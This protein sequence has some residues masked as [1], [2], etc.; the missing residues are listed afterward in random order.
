MDAA[1]KAASSGDGMSKLNHFKFC[2]TAALAIVLIVA[3]R[4]SAQDPPEISLGLN[5][6]ATYYGGDIDS[7]DMTTGRLKL[8]IPLLTDNSQRGGLNF[9]YNLSYSSPGGWNEV[10]TSRCYWATSKYGVVGVGVTGGQFVS[11]YGV[12]TYKG[13][14]K[15]F[16]MYYATDGDGA[17]HTL[18]SLTQNVNGYWSSPARS[19]DGSKIYAYTNSL[20]IVNLVNAKG[21]QLVNPSPSPSYIEDANGNQITGPFIGSFLS[22][23][24]KSG[25]STDTLGRV[26][27]VASTTSLSDCPVAATLGYIWTVPGYNGVSRTFKFCYTSISWVTAFVWGG[28]YE[29]GGTN[30]MITGVVLPNGTT[31]RFDYDSWGDLQKVF[32]PTGGT[33]TYG[34]ATTMHTGCP[35]GGIEPLRTVASRTVSDGTTNQTWNYSLPGS[36]GMGVTVT[37]PLNNTTVYTGHVGPS[38]TCPGTISN[39]QYYSNGTL[40][41]TVATTFLDIPDP[42]QNNDMNGGFVDTALPT[43]ITTT[44]NATNQVSQSTKSYDG[45]FTFY[46]NNWYP[47][48]SYISPYGMVVTETESD[49]GSPGAGAGP[50]LVTT[51]SNYAALVNPSYLSANLLDLPTSVL[52]NGSQGKCSEVDYGYDVGTPTAYSGAIQHSGTTTS[53]RGNLTS[54]TKQIYTNPCQSSTPT[55]IGSLTT[56]RTFYDTGM[57]LNSTDP[58]GNITG[59][60]YSTSF[61]G[62]YVTSVNAAGFTTNY[63]YDF[64]SGRM[65]SMTDPNGQTTN[66]GPYDNMLRLTQVQRPDGGLETATFNDTVSY[67][68]SPNYTYTKK[69]NSSTTFTK[70]GIVDG[71]GRAIKTKTSVPSSTCASNYTYVDT[72]YDKDGRQLSVSNPYCV[73]TG[74]ATYGVT[75]TYYDGLNRP[76]LVVPPDGTLPSGNT[77][78][79]TSPANDIFTT[80][81]GNTSTV[82]DQ[83]GKVRKAQTDGLGRLTSVWEDPN[84]LNYQT[85]Y[86]YDGLNNLL[87]VLQNGSRQRTFTYDSLSRLEQASNPESGTTCYAP[88][89]GG[90]CQYQNAPGYDGDGNPL[91]KTD[92]RGIT[93]N[94]TYDTHN[95]LTGK[96]YTD[97]TPAVSYYYDGAAP[98]NCSVGS[99]NY[100]NYPLGRRT[101]MCDAA[102]SEA[103]S[104]DNVGRVA[105]DQRTTNGI[106]K[107]ATYTPNYDGSIASIAY[108]AGAAITYAPNVAGQPV[109]AVD[110]TNSINYTSGPSNCPNGQPALTVGVLKGACYNPD[111]SLAA[112]KNGSSLISTW[113]ENNRL[114][115]CRLA[116]VNSIGTAPISCSDSTN[117][118]N[119]MDLVYDFGLA[120]SDNGNV[121]GITNKKDDTRSQVFTYDSLNRI[122][123]A[124]TTSTHSTSP[125]NCWSEVYQYDNLT[126]GGAWGNLTNIGAGPSQYN[127]CTQESGLSITV[128][129]NNQ[130]STSG[131][132]YDSAG[133]LTGNGSIGLRYD[134]ES[135]ICSIGGTSC[136][137]GTT[138]VYDGDGRR[139]EK[140]ASGSAYKLYWYDTSG[141]VLDETDGA[142]ST[143]NS[144]FN[145]YVFFRGNRIAKRNS[146]GAVSYYFADSLGTAR[147]VTDSTGTVPPLDDSDYY[148]FG[149]ERDVLFSSGNAYKFTGKERDSE[150]GLDNFGAR[151]YSSQNARF[152]SSDPKR[153][154]A[155][156]IDPQ[157]WNRYAYTE[158]NPL[159]YVDPDG[160]DLKLAAG[161]SK[162]DKNRIVHDLTQLYR[163]ETGR[164]ALQQLGSSDITYVV[165]AGKL[166]GKTELGYTHGEGFT[167]TIDPITGKPANVDRTSGQV[168]IT[169]DFKKMDDRKAID[170]KTTQGEEQHTVDHEIAGHAVDFDNNPAAEQNKSFGQAEFDADKAAYTVEAEK[171]SMHGKDAENEVREILNEPK[172]SKRSDQD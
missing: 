136:I 141:N 4:V 143:A 57:L 125:A 132:A 158:N 107:T 119:V 99:F 55:Q 67:P 85:V 106:T 167:G 152:T 126:S 32:M 124:E 157:S 112:L 87:S 65:I 156:P 60:G 71:M 117:H 54:I 160:M 7:V 15:T 27:S 75:T 36:S 128:N 11:G 138:Y 70:I 34:W 31:W 53:F 150:S 49:Y 145:E 62:A 74:E 59:Y 48:P 68:N 101:A 40:V 90:A 21:I 35:S 50:V 43:Q 84:G 121:L 26:W 105:Q 129:S 77:C 78:P 120:F 33:I 110:T 147:V 118:G 3:S 155:L 114:Q 133:N 146:S 123:T 38:G 153:S 41:K 14:T 47:I 122:L 142:G 81:S 86:T 52:V 149:G 130:I 6:Q 8:H 111:A 20:G 17:N 12:S 83:A 51:S 63:N 96:T 79:A 61:Y 82:T 29:K 44:W 115:P 30:S 103:W 102:G 166:G 154:S 164:A 22:G 1:R 69:I 18:G 168:N 94:Y 140:T 91:T 19:I 95:R 39:A 170:P 37:D 46:D 16:F 23:V 5:P 134:A 139:A 93:T 10:C 131:F 64:S 108:P 72:V 2:C 161:L 28:V 169:L 172:K 73:T 25:S 171:N 148:P 92:A 162:A 165:R 137:T 144:N 76:C 80:Y 104:Y 151:S 88:Y 116:V 58:K 56:N 89:S 9:S 163:K 113:Y 159:K 127:G 45:G 97:S 66:Y 24:T 109:T 98:T 13:G 100:G 42:Y 135:R